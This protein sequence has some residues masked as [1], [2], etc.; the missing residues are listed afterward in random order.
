[1]NPRIGILSALAIVL[2]ASCKHEAMVDGPTLLTLDIPS[3]MPPMAIPGD[4]PLT[5]EGV[6]LGRHLFYEELLSGDNTMSCGSCHAPEFAFTDHGNQFSTGIDGIAGNRNSMAL[7]NLGWDNFYFWD[8]RSATLE[9]QILE[10]VPNPI[11]MHESWQNATAELYTSAKYQRMFMDAFGSPDID[12]I[13]VSKAIAQFLRTMISGNSRF[14]KMMRFEVARTPQEDSAI[15]LFQAEGGIG[16]YVAPDGSLVIG[17]GGADCFHCHSMTGGLL[18]DGQ[19][20]NNAL[21]SVFVDLGAGG[22]TG[23]PGDFGKFKT[24]TLKNIALTA[25]YMH[26]GRFQTLE[27][28]IDHYN[29]GGH[30]SATVDPFMKFTHPD[31]S[32][33]LTPAKKAQLLHLLNT[34]TDWEFVNNPAFSDPDP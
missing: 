1:M 34:M 28:V 3:N 25:P 15:V 17:Q 29:S 13:K 14:D 30:F 18:N 5:V 27:E 31:S 21:D 19:L 2:L 24:P 22:V 23:N 9:E 7:I 10:P 32:L 20:H 4:N 11:E 16:Q 6:E 26:D 12:S 8:G 33:G